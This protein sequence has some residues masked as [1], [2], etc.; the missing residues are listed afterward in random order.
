MQKQRCS[1]KK[2]EIHEPDET[3]KSL[4]ETRKQ[5]SR[6]RAAAAR[7]ASQR[8]NVVTVVKHFGQEDG[9][10]KR[11]RRYGDDPTN[12]VLHAAGIALNEETQGD[13]VLQ[14][15]EYQSESENS[16]DLPLSR[17]RKTELKMK[18]IQPME[19]CYKTRRLDLDFFD[20]GATGSVDNLE[21]FWSALQKQEHCV[22]NSQEMFVFH[23]VQLVIYGLTMDS[24]ELGSMKSVCQ[25]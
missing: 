11:A 7:G 3:Q 17:N 25:S 14:L 22:L 21:Q 18:V 2:K 12:P 20:P 8:R 16:S 5:W 9:C 15:V 6:D 4:G 10:P 19:L 24:R 13:A 1:S 23:I